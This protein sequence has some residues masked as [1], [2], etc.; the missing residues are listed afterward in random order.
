MR[1]RARGV[2]TLIAAASLVL[3]AASAGA[4]DAGAEDK[5]NP[6]MTSCKMVFN[7]KGWSLGIASSKGEGTI[8]CDNGQTAEVSLDSK[9]V[10]FTVGKSAIRGG[11]GSFSPVSDIKELYGDYGALKAHAGAGSSSGAASVL[12][13]GEV[14]L[15]LSGAGQGVDLGVSIGRLAVEPK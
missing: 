5:Y 10:G 4:E 15:S 11:Q 12:T 2:R 14:S 13:R 1:D 3:F 8:S 9:A 7:I 6:E